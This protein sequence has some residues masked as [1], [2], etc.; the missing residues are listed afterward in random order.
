MDYPY[1]SYAQLVCGVRINNGSARCC[2]SRHVLRAEAR[3]WRAA[4]DRAACASARCLARRIAEAARR[5]HRA[6]PDSID[7]DVGAHRFMPKTKA[8]LEDQGTAFE[9]LL[10][11]LPVLLSVAGLDPARTIRPQHPG[12]WQRAALRRLEKLRERGLE[13]LDRRDLAAGRGL[14]HRAVRQVH[15]PL[16]ARARGVPPGW[17]D[18]YAAATLTELRL[19]LNENGRWC[20]TAASP[21]TI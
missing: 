5:Q 2:C 7:E 17:S 16:R 18:W 10:R 21:R 4:R 19:R 14:P 13:E 11:Q 20:T 6:D 15:Q 9:E 8:L 12:R 1:R 3:S